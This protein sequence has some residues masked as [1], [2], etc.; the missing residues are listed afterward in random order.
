[1]LKLYSGLA[2]ILLLTSTAYAE[3]APSFLDQIKIDGYWRS[4]YFSRDYSKNTLPMQT[5]FSLGGG[6]NVATGEFLP[7]T[8]AVMSLYFAQSLGL[9]SND[10]NRVDNTLPGSNIVT[11]GQAYLQYQ[12]N[13]VLL[14]VG[15]QLID[16]PWLNAGDARMIPITYQGIYG[17]YSPTSDLKLIG[18]R[19]LQLKNR[20]ASHFANQGILGLGMQYKLGNLNTQTW[21]YRSYNLAANLLYFDANYEFNNNASIKPITG[22]QLF[23]EW[24]TSKDLLK[25]AIN[26]MGY[27]ILL[28]AKNASN[29]LTVGYNFIAANPNAFQQGSIISICNTADDPL[30]TGSMIGDLVDT[31]PGQAIKITGTHSMLN[32][33]LRLSMS[34]AKYFTAPQQPNTNEWDLDTNYSFSGRFKG[35]TARYRIGILDGDKTTGQ[36]IYSRLM[37]QYNF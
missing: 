31:A 6:V 4:Y 27:G 14:R 18:L 28:G 7:H 37:L 2:G 16:T 26:A 29:E 15:N 10:P 24:S 25:P 23:R 30:Y 20:T 21:Y 12:N 22:V 3:S 8:N 35:L 11:L 13:N 5:A 34:Y 36:F 17:E 9:N 1:M 33:Q 32:K 19:V